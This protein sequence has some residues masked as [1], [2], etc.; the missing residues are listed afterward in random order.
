MD[1]LRDGAD[2]M[3]APIQQIYL[4][5]KMGSAINAEKYWFNGL[6]IP[7]VGHDATPTGSLT[8]W[9]NGLPAPVIKVA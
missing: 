6:P 4:A 8:Y 2:L 5:I 1:H 9:F 3:A 7:G